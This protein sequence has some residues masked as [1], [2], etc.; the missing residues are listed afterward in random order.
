MARRQWEGTERT[1]A[2]RCAVPVGERVRGGILA[3]LLGLFP[4]A[5]AGQPI[6]PIVTAPAAAG[7]RAPYEAVWNATL[8][9]LGAVRP[10][11]VDRPNGHIVT[12]RYSFTMPVQGGGGRGG[13]VITQVLNVSLDIQ[14]RPAQDG[15]T[16]VQAQTTVHDALEYGFMPGP[17]G[18]NSPE[19]DLF[20]RI[21][22][23]LAGR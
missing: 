23:R 1:G 8:Q 17:G 3:A 21:A 16:A 14:V 4:A 11:L 22:D 19:G 7:F 6:Y 9:S 13:S 18:P 2:R 20:A 10:A 5:C 15:A 12:E